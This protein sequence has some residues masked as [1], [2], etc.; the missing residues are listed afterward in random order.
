[1]NW[2][3]LQINGI[4][5][6]A[7]RNRMEMEHKIELLFSL[8]RCQWRSCHGTMAL[9]KQFGTKSSWYI[10]Y[11]FFI[12]HSSVPH[13]HTSV[14]ASSVVSHPSSENICE[15]Q[16]LTIT[17]TD[18]RHSLLLGKVRRHLSRKMERTLYPLTLAFA[19]LYAFRISAYQNENWKRRRRI[20]WI[21][22][23][24]TAERATCLC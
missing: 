20:M 1:M 14:I 24:K 3:V 15:N 22:C 12:Y 21:F 17:A 9:A 5:S 11:S 2:Q 10:V 4:D 18:S 13:I 16:R 6:M 8:S 23:K 7:R 19:I